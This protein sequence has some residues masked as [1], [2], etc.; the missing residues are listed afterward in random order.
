MK[1]VTQRRGDAT[2]RRLEFF[3]IFFT[4]SIFH[5][6]RRRVP[7]GL[8]KL[9]VQVAQGLD[10]DVRHAKV[11]VPLPVGR[12]H[13]PGRVFRGGA[14]DEVLVGSHELAPARAVLKVVGIE[15]PEWLGSVRAS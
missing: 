2:K 1:W 12:D 15:F 14:A 9:K 11:A 6:D 5:L 13:I 7:G 3:G 4:S 8:W 10:H